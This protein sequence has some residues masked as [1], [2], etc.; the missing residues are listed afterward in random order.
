VADQWAPHG[1][2]V[3]RVYGNRGP[4]ARDNGRGSTRT[5]SRPG[6]REMGCGVYIRPKRLIG[7]IFSFYFR[8]LPPNSIPISN[9]PS[10]RINT[11]INMTST[12]FNIIIYYFPYYLFM[13]GI[14]GFIKIPSLIFLIPFLFLNSIFSLKLVSYM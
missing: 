3:A 9:L 7:L 4:H 14:N 5:Q 8:V 6:K 1:G 10:V 12:I 11:N 13:G 2:G